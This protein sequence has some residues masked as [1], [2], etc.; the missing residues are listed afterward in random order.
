MRTVSLDE[1]VQLIHAASRDG[2]GAFWY[3]IG[4]GVSAPYIPLAR[5]II[6]DCGE[7]VPSVGDKNPSAAV[8]K[9]YENALLKK[10]PTRDLQRAYFEKI[11]KDVPITEATFLLANQIAYRRPAS[12]VVTTNFDTSLSDTV[13]LLSDQIVAV[14]ENPTDAPKFHPNDRKRIQI[15]HAHGV[16]WAYDI[17]NLAS[18]IQTHQHEA[19]FL[20]DQLLANRSVIVLGYSGW[21]HDL[22]MTRL[23]LYLEKPIK[24]LLIWC[25]YK[26]SDLNAL[27]E[28]LRDSGDKSVLFVQPEPPA[29][30]H[31][32]EPVLDAAVVLS[33]ISRQLAVPAPSLIRNPM[34]STAKRIRGLILHP[35]AKSTKPVCAALPQATLAIRR[36]AVGAR[37]ER[38][39]RDTR[40]RLQAVFDKITELRGAA[41]YHAIPAVLNSLPKNL[42][43]NCKH[44]EAE[45][46]WSTIEACNV[47]TRDDSSAEKPLLETAVRLCGIFGNS[48]SLE[49]P[50][51]TGVD[52]WMLRS[53]DYRRR[54][55]RWL[56]VQPEYGGDETPVPLLEKY[57][58]LLIDSAPLANRTKL[59]RQVAEYMGRLHLGYAK[60]LETEGHLSRARM[61]YTR[62]VRAIE[63]A[64]D[65]TAQHGLLLA[66]ARFGECACLILERK[67]SVADD[68][69]RAFKKQFSKSGDGETARLVQLLSAKWAKAVREQR[70][71]R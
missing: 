48:L 30:T 36:L 7:S 27:P 15:Y 24:H 45:F 50:N 53:L 3:M 25:L 40:T 26:R 49:P 70:R 10:Y 38:R 51:K 60:A 4:A 43:K 39:S 41:K 19:A 65:S 13:S 59:S 68:A 64:G 1:A 66:H 9:A 69:V 29:A 71:S 12:F 2:E 42:L 17:K 11:T 34:L 61:Q 21:E 18:D 54:L 22:F 63:R 58:Q 16:P 8:S 23:R 52:R 67:E 46:V 6:I 57:K 14:G 35:P 33:A 37:L 31:T 5:E 55:L 47:A 20:L 28:W 62:A 44:D 56:R 32:T